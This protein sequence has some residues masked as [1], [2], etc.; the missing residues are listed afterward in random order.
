[1]PF[2]ILFG[3]LIPLPLA[4][5]F[6]I[7]YLLNNRAHAVM[8][9]GATDFA[10][11]LFASSGFVI[12]GG[13]FALAGF[14]ARAR[15]YLLLGPLRRMDAYDW[16]LWISI[17]I[18]YLLAVI[19]ASALLLMRRRRATAIYNMEPA[20]FRQAFADTLDRLRLD[21][22]RDGDQ[23]FIAVPETRSEPLPARHR[24]T[25][26]PAG[27]GHWAAVVQIDTFPAMSHVAL[28]WRFAPA[29]LRREV[30]T[31]LEE[32]LETIPARPNPAAPW[33]FSIAGSLYALM[34]FTVVALIAFVYFLGQA[35]QQ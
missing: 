6:S 34:L 26:A 27:A 11:V 28:W 18:G 35:Q 32:L 15:D 13:P 24:E 31:D 17:W 4:I 22:L 14:H 1:M 19:A 33:M 30:E 5:Y 9:S 20:A 12:F 8:V 29:S 23:V 10:L 7:L 16:R 25:P 3:L 21:W 2:V